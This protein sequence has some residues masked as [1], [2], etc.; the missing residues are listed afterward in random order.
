MSTQKD[1]STFVG[2]IDQVFASRK[3]VVP[4]VNEATTQ[5]EAGQAAE[6]GHAAGAISFG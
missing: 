1:V 6:V 2:F 4:H 3:S 5:E